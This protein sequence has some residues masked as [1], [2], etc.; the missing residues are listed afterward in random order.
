MGGQRMAQWGGQDNFGWNYANKVFEPTGEYL[1]AVDTTM[2]WLYKLRAIIGAALLIAIGI[3]YHQSVKSV[4]ANFNPV[5]G[6]VG[7]FTGPLLLGL[8]LVVPSTA[9][10]VWYTKKEKRA[11]AFRQMLRYPVKTAVIC[12]GIYEFFRGLDQV[13]RALHDS[14]NSSAVDFVG[15]AGSIVCLRYFKFFFRGIYL[16]TVG[17]FRMG[18]G[19]PLLPPVVGSI[20]PWVP[21]IKALA[22]GP[23]GTGEPSPIWVAALIAGPASV[24]LLGYAEIR[25]LRKEHRAEFPFRDGPLPALKSNQPAEAGPDEPVTGK[26]EAVHRGDQ[27]SP[28]TGGQQKP[29]AA[30]WSD[31]D[32]GLLHAYKLYHHLREGGPVEFIPAAN[33]PVRLKSREKCLA[34]TKATL[35]QWQPEKHRYVMVGAGHLVLTDWDLIHSAKGH[36]L[37]FR[38]AGVTV[39]DGRAPLGLPGDH[40]PVGIGFEFRTAKSYAGYWMD[41]PAADRRYVDFMIKHV[42]EE[43]RYYYGEFKTPAGFIERARALGKL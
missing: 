13:L 18:D 41:L 38:R 2:D 23:A 21:A 29:P 15:I 30:P 9:A 1:Q 4:T 32:K 40:S 10:V 42:Y 6:G 28:G 25:R 3:R 12:L 5:L 39:N 7:G 14:G 8:L 17:L 37:R 31:E 19:H 24:T 33:C 43:L 36:T 35:Y 20:T 22:S 16:V 34:V 11:E 27:G 26:A